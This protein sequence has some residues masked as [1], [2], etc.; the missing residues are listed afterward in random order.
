MRFSKA[1]LSLAVASTLLL[2]AN[3]T[4]VDQPAASSP[5]KPALSEDDGGSRLD[6]LE[7]ELYL[8]GTSP[9]FSE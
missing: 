6:G 9:A 5:A 2:A 7:L 3:N 4:Q 8:E 1:L